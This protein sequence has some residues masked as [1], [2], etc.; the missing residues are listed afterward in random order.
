M[1]KWMRS[2]DSSNPS[3]YE[4]NV[5]RPALLRGALEKQVHRKRLV[6]SSLPILL[7]TVKLST[8]ARE[9]FK[10]GYLWGM[11]THTYWVQMH[12]RHG[13]FQSYL[14]QIRKARFPNCAFG[15]EVIDD[16]ENNF[17]LVKGR[18]AFVASFMQTHESSFQATLSEG[19]W[20]MESRCAL[21]SGFF[22]AEKIE[23]DRRQSRIAS[24]SLKLRLPSSP[25]V[26]EKNSLTWRHPKS[27]K[28]QGQPEVIYPTLPG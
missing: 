25:F 22:V 14:N 9:R 1:I 17:S 13:D 6:W 7:R 24:A 3:S 4:S 5:V 28:R 27:E 11:P 16:T 8:T 19:C 12:R 10:R 23:P 18:M 20:H 15:N 21:F 2:R 26:V